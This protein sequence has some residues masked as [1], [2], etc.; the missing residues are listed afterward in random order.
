MGSKKKISFEEYYREIYGDRWDSLKE[1]LLTDADNFCISEGLLKPYYLDKASTAAAAALGVKP[2][3]DVLDMC[4]APG[5]KTLILALA[6]NG[7]GSLISNDRSS[8]RRRRLRDVID[9]HL[10]AELRARINV[11]GHDAACWGLH[12]QNIYDRILLD[13]P[14]SS[15]EHVLKSPAH[16]KRW[17]PARTKQLSIQAHAMLAA[18]VDALKPGGTIVY[19]TCALSPIENDNV[20]AKLLKKRSGLVRID[21][22]SGMSSDEEMQGLTAEKTEYGLH[23]LPDRNGGWGPIFMTKI[24]KNL[25]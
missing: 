21:D 16:L 13:A 5:G 19:S 17:S 12:E 9:T 3:D 20:I 14:C 11:T 4:A 24:L 25:I 1:A 8:D 22:I 7:S 15:E 10:N 2:G 18:A 23:I 6:L